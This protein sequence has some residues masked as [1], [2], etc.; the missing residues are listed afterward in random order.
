ML[1]DNSGLN[2]DS[3]TSYVD[4]FFVVPE[5]YFDVDILSFEN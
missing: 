3:K 1:V 2:H 5:K 4:S